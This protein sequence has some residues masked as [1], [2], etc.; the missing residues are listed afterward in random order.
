MNP[1]LAA[2]PIDTLYKLKADIDEVADKRRHEVFR[3]GRLVRF[4]DKQ[5]APLIGRIESVG[6]KNLSIQVLNEKGYPTIGHGSKWRC[7]PSFCQPVFGDPFAKPA[8]KPLFTANDRP[9]VAGAGAF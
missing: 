2:L 9:A 5:G 8:P 4:E 7:N 6:P 3:Q 1:K